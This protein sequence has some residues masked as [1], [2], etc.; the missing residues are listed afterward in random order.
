LATSSGTERFAI[1][2]QRMKGIENEL[3]DLRYLADG[4]VNV[5][6]VPPKRAIFT[7]KAYGRS[8]VD[9]TFRYAWNRIALSPNGLLLAVISDKE[10]RV[11][12]L[13]SD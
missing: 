8:P 13:P 3:I 5:Y 4:R 12:A 10:A 9:W 2:F 11:Y 1:I 7:V 6:S